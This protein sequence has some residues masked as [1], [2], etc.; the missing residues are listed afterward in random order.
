MFSGDTRYVFAADY[1]YSLGQESLVPGHRMVLSEFGKDLYPIYLDVKAAKKRAAQ[2]AAE[3]IPASVDAAGNSN[4][5][6]VME[7]RII[8]EVLHIHGLQ[9]ALYGEVME[10]V[11][12][13]SH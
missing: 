6:K 1:V 8:L 9:P 2:E 10:S 13:P 4:L 5:R 3:L 7:D 11:E 12:K